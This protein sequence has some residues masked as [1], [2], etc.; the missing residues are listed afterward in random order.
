M[1]PKLLQGEDGSLLCLSLK[2]IQSRTWEIFL[3]KS[4]LFPKKS[5]CLPVESE[6][7]KETESKTV[8]KVCVGAC[9][10]CFRRQTVTRKPTHSSFFEFSWREQAA[11]GKEQP[12]DCV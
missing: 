6:S 12:L 8:A 3:K 10:L 7:E 9:A 11:V 5:F 1:V 2:C 4:V